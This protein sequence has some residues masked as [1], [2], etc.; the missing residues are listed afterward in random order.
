M[1]TISPAM[2]REQVIEKFGVLL[3]DDKL[4]EDCE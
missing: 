2:I 1:A 3:D 4:A